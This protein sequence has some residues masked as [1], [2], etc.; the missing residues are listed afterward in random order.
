[1]CK[2]KISFDLGNKDKMGK[3]HPVAFFEKSTISCSASVLALQENFH[4]AHLVVF[5]V[6]RLQLCVAKDIISTMW[7]N[8]E[9]H[10]T[11][12]E[13]FRQAW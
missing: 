11:I 5:G 7:Q 1:M 2:N 10:D 6:S 4:L 8:I 9:G 3:T 13:R 12:V